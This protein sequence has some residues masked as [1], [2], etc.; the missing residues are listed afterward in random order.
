MLSFP[1]NFSLAS[2]AH[3]ENTSA[4]LLGLYQRLFPWISRTEGSNQY[5]LCAP[6]M[7]RP[8]SGSFCFPGCMVTG[9]TQKVKC[10]EQWGEKQRKSLYVV[11]PH[12]WFWEVSVC[13]YQLED[14][15][16]RG[17][18]DLQIHKETWQGVSAGL[19]L[20]ERVSIVKNILLVSLNE[21][22]PSCV[23]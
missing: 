18:K 22:A 3:G 17:G 23:S 21:K 8:D 16:R 13:K 6:Y 4:A 7:A 9:Q 1:P 14:Q 10:Q 11:P 20:G 5:S 12:V 15:S 2:L 19:R